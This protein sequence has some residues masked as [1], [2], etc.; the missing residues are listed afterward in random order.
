M[1]VRRAVDM[2]L[3]VAQRKG[4]KKIYT[5]GPLIHNPQTVEILRKRGIIPADNIGE[6]EEGTIVIR[7]HGI[8]PLERKKIEEKNMEIIDA[9]C[10][11]VLRVQAIIKKHASLGC[12]ILIVGDRKHPEVDGLLGYSGSKGIVIGDRDEIDGL[13]D[14]DKI[15]VVAQTT[16]NVEE[17]SNVVNV[18]RKRFPKTTVFNTICDSTEKRQAEVKELSSEMDI[19]FIVGGKNSANT[20][21]LARVSELQGT[22]TFHIETVDDLK[23]IST[24]RYEK[25]G[26]SAGA[27]TPNWVIERIV[28]YLTRHQRDR[29]K[30]WMRKPLN[31]WVLTV[32]TDIYSAIGAGCL[33][34]A[35]MLLQGLNV[36]IFNIMT[37][38]F[39]VY[40]MHTLN[41]FIDRKRNSIISSFREDSYLKHKKVYVSVAIISLLLAL[42]LSLL[43]GMAPFLL[44]LLISL[45]GA[46]YN[47]R[48]LP[49]NWSFKRLKDIPGSKNVSMA[50]AWGIVTAVVPQIGVSLSVTAG[51]ISAFLF[52]FA[53]VF[54]RSAMHDVS[55][56]QSDR[57]IGRETIPVLIGEENTRKLLKGILVIMA[58]VLVAAHP[59]GWTSS[60]S[61]ALLPCVFYAWICFRF[62]DR[63]MRLSVAVL[64]GILETNYIIAGLVAFLWLILVR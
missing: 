59:A 52:T 41:R 55:D 16:Q 37:A 11:K 34:L 25:I 4:N 47:T 10:P 57:L 50:A 28:N 53:V 61:L 33:S 44:L 20:K 17:Y 48:I 27:S 45:L 29:K 58:A 62:C 35:G 19:M 51:T 8:S 49:Q 32:T 54:V 46:L 13:R 39:Y 31:F 9:T 7:A 15:C 64:E 42:A 3:D 38:S 56:I 24:G 43:T 1:G 23:K 26:I 14:L 30:E 2:A 21:R 40:S 60:L 22:P 63:K 18:I 6:I 5:Y 12:T 36:N